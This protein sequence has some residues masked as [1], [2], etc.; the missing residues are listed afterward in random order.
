MLRSVASIWILVAV[1]AGTSSAARAQREFGLEN[2]GWN[3]FS[4]LRAT[5]DALEIDLVQPESVD[6]D[7]LTRDD[8]LLIVHPTRDLPE[9]SLQR[10]LSEGGRLAILDDFGTT[11]PFLSHY[12][13]RSRNAQSSHAA[14]LRGNAELPVAHPVG[15]HVLTAGIRGVVTNHPAELVHE[16]L[17]PI[18]QF[19]GSDG[20]V[21]LA[22]AVGGGRLIAAS[23]SSLFINNMMAFAD[24][25]ALASTLLDY[26]I[27]ERPRRILVVAGNTEWTGAYRDANSF[28][29]RLRQALEALRSTPI[30]KEAVRTLS[31]TLAALMIVLATTLLPTRS[32]YR[33]ER[34]FPTSEFQSGFSAKVRRAKE[35]SEGRLDA[36]LGYRA[37]VEGPL[38][39]LATHG[40]GE[41]AQALD[42][43]RAAEQ[44]AAEG[45]G[46]AEST[47]DEIVRD[48]EAALAHAGTTA[49]AGKNRV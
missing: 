28:R 22:G 18:L 41:A 17:P 23:D 1:S 35:S 7:L 13:I 42:A 24:N 34:M 47:F 20:A 9:R 37:A 46:L 48:A 33:S 27:Q 19:Q 21:L 12:G 3:G 38:A 6:L 39:E 30:P 31:I 32:P 15:S 11:S 14:L 25:R 43:L 36:L 10:F 44:H 26:M 4:E 16:K 49:A 40:Q 8:A 45:R 2:Q 29:E 5:A